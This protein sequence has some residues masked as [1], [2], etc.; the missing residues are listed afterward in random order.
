MIEGESSLFDCRKEHVMA[1]TKSFSLKTKHLSLGS[2][3]CSPD[4]FCEVAL[5]TLRHFFAKELS[6]ILAQKT[7]KYL[8]ICHG[9]FVRGLGP[10]SITVMF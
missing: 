5:V 1:I 9:K 7:R 8:K 6:S 10:S 3:V 2:S 4:L